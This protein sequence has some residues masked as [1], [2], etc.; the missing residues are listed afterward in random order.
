[1]ELPLLTRMCIA[2]YD[3]MVAYWAFMAIVA[4][5]VAAFLAFY[6]RTGTGQLIRDKLLLE[7]APAGAAVSPRP[8]CPVCQ[9]LFDPAIQRRG[10]AGVD[11]D[12]GR[13]GEQCRHLP[14]NSPN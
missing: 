14:R 11:A 3:F 12:T 2:M 7:P 9:H 5:I 6:L 8:P 13:H 4:V 10:H 1:M